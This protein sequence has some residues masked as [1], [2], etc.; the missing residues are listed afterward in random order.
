MSVLLIGGLGVLFVLVAI[1]VLRL[2][3][4]IALLLGSLL[5]LL[6]TPDE[7]RLKVATGGKIHTAIEAEGTSLTLD[8]EIPAG[9]YAMWS[10]DSIADASKV[11]VSKAITYGEPPN[12]RY[13]YSV[14]RE[15]QSA[16]GETVVEA[17]GTSRGNQLAEWAV[18]QEVI[19]GR[20]GRIGAALTQGF[21]KTFSKL[22]IP[23]TMAA[24]VG[25]CL[26]ESGAAGRLVQL[27]TGMFGPKGTAPAMTLSAFVLGVPVYFDNVFYLL[28]PLAKA[29]GRRRSELF[30]SSVM[31][32]IVGATMA[33]SLVPPTPGPLL[34]AGL[35]DVSVGMF[36]IGGLCVGGSAA[37]VG[38][39]Y[40]MACRKWVNFSDEQLRTSL[41]QTEEEETSSQSDRPAPPLWLAAIPI[42]FPIVLLACSELT[43]YWFG[44]RTEQSPPWYGLL[45]LAKNPSIVFIVTALI[46]IAILRRYTTAKHASASVAKAISDAGT[47][48]LLTCAGGALGASLQ[49]LDLAGAISESFDSF[50]SP[51]GLLTTAFLLTTIIRA[52]Q[53]SAT[54]A[55]ITSASIIAPVI[56]DGMELP[57]HPIYV[58]LAIGCGSKPLPWMN[59]SGFWQV[60]TMTGMTPVQT[61]KSFSVALTLM[62]LT[63]FLVT[64]LGACLLPLV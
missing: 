3:P 59:D 22:G 44:E 27:I 21:A 16:S 33:H 46:S 36:M 45:L 57:F 2:H 12:D 62:G 29:V 58:A 41:A 4:L 20:F 10:E 40:G 7:T 60:A 38:F 49:Q 14:T 19:P 50:A 32:I 11:T 47:I 63:G 8:H 17:V 23:V 54:V 13:V 1:L 30:L 24:I 6:A 18:Y 61:L 53:G 55:M 26:L 15:I 56:A 48:V 34:V 31:A 43:L 37:A 64:L 25:I 9:E 52:A 39:L 51:W 42:A 5:L 35:M 28:L